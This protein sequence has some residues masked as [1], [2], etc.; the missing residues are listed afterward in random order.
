MKSQQLS[1]TL[2]VGIV[3]FLQAIAADAK[4]GVRVIRLGPDQ[5]RVEIISTRLVETGDWLTET[6]GYTELGTGLNYWNSKSEQW[7]ASAEEIELL[8]VG[9]AALRAPHKVYFAPSLDDPQGAVDVLAPDGSRFRSSVLALGYYDPVSGRRHTLGLVKDVPGEL[10]PPNQV[11]YRDAFASQEP[12]FRIRCD[13]LYTFRRSGIEQDILIREPVPPPEDFGLSAERA[14]LEVMTEFFEAPEPKRHARLLDRVENSQDRAVMA[15]PDWEDESL[16]FGHFLIG[17]GRAFRLG[18]QADVFSDG[19]NAPLVAKRWVVQEGRSV[20]LEAVRY[21][22]VEPMLRELAMGPV[23]PL[24]VPPKG[25]AKFKARGGIRPSSKDRSQES[26]STGSYNVAL[27]TGPFLPRRPA[28]SSPHAGR[29]MAMARHGAH[30]SPAVVLD[31]VMLLVDTNNFTFRGDE[32]YHIS[33]MINLGSSTFSVGGMW[34]H[35]AA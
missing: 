17:D 34:G 30:T 20:L 19:P 11:I 27:G 18:R 28:K 31:Y 3:I 9:A 35:P 5:Q 10:L 14:Q 25:V 29:T 26:M 2:I 6:N 8:Q 12:G 21:S 22:D 24:Q 1:P 16:D 32:T 23:G 15:S 13:V 33:S 7:E 4:D